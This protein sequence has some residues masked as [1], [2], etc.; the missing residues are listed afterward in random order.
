MHYHPT[1]PLLDMPPLLC[2]KYCFVIASTGWCTCLHKSIQQHKPA[3]LVVLPGL[4]MVLL[5]IYWPIAL[6][7]CLQTMCKV[8][9]LLRKATVSTCHICSSLGECGRGPW[10]GFVNGVLSACMA[11][12]CYQSYTSCRKKF[13]WLQDLSAGWKPTAAATPANHKQQQ[14]QVCH[15]LQLRQQKTDT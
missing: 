2:M 12:R 5:T 6:F 14:F 15:E 4:A 13:Q 7:H 3:C 10:K 11:H 8:F 9:G 1:C